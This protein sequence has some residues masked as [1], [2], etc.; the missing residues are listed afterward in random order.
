MFQ[1]VR[2]KQRLQKIY[3]QT[4]T[5]SLKVLL[6]FLLLLANAKQLKAYTSNTGG[7]TTFEVIS[8]TKIVFYMHKHC[9]F[10][11][12]SYGDT[13]DFQLFVMIGNTQTQVYP[14]YQYFHYPQY[15]CPATAATSPLTFGFGQGV[16]YRELV[17]KYTLDIS[18]K[19]FD[20]L[21]KTQPVLRIFAQ[22]KELSPTSWLIG[23]GTKWNIIYEPYHAWSTE[24]NTKSMVKGDKS[25][26]FNNLNQRQF[27]Q[28]EA[29]YSN[30]GIVYNPNDSVFTEL[31]PM[32]TDIW[33][34]SVLYTS[35]FSHKYP[36]TSY[37]PT[38]GNACTPKPNNKNKPIGFHCDPITGAIT[39]FHSS[40]P[41]TSYYE[42]AGPIVFKTSWY[43]KDAS[44]NWQFKGSITVLS[45]K[46]TCTDFNKFWDVPNFEVPSRVD[47][48]EGDSATINITMSDTGYLDT[49]YVKIDGSLNPKYYRYTV[50]YSVKY[51]P[52]I[53]LFI[54][55]PL[56]ADFSTYRTLN[57]ILSNSSCDGNQLSSRGIVVYN[58]KSISSKIITYPGPCNSFKA[59]IKSSNNGMFV[60][61]SWSVYKDS[62]GSKPIYTGKGDV[63]TLTAL[64]KGKY[65]LACTVS[66]PSAYC[67]QRIFRDSVDLIKLWPGLDFSLNH[68]TL[69]TAD[70]N[71]L[72]TPIN[73]SGFASKTTREWRFDTT[74]ITKDTLRKNFTSAVTLR[75]RITDTA[76]CDFSKSFTLF[77]DSVYQLD[78][79]TLE[80]L[81]GAQTVE[82]SGS[83]TV[84]GHAWSGDWSIT[85]GT[86]TTDLGTSK[87]LSLFLDAPKS[88]ITGKFTSVDGCAIALMREVKVDTTQIRI[89][90]IAVVCKATDTFN[91]NNIKVTPSGGTWWNAESNSATLQLK[92]AN[93]DSMMAIYTYSNSQC[94]FMDSAWVPLGDTAKQDFVT[95]KA[96]CGESAREDLTNLFN[97]STTGGTWYSKQANVSISK[98]LVIPRNT[99][100]NTYPVYYFSNTSP[101]GQLETH[102]LT[103]N[104][105][106]IAIDAKSN[107]T[108]AQI[109]ATILFEAKNLL[110]TA[111]TTYRWF[112][113]DP[114]SGSND[115][116]QVSSCSHTYTKASTYY[117]FVIAKAGNCVDTGYC[118]PIQVNPLSIQGIQS[119][120]FRVYPNPWSQSQPLAI[121]YWGTP[122]N[123]T[124]G[125]K[126]LM[127][128]YSAAGQLIFSKEMPSSGELT[129]SETLPIGVYYLKSNRTES[130]IKLI[131]VP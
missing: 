92:K 13:G 126:S 31:V 6:I 49:I 21:L 67:S 26:S 12:F 19:P 119:A 94:L 54:K 102:W 51:L 96:V 48:C 103:V 85:T 45:I 64:E 44:G 75:L 78:L 95:P 122:T 24:I 93:S 32:E 46:L 113:N 61:N 63:I 89:P 22:T 1:F 74:K 11:K 37:C 107:T 77:K 66:S 121:K 59:Q 7:Y 118:A 57:V 109:P 101:C 35:N 18:Q 114:T 131:V 29:N 25:V 4:M 71:Q 87:K 115:S 56:G 83:N 42:E 60:S 80:T 36:F 127:M 116:A 65:Y 98:G 106:V 14:T 104:P 123:A 124:I 40:R 129:I 108:T 9:P 117:P 5:K 27:I 47:I 84:T 58:Q 88:T 120:G 41:I 112:F 38:G 79:P 68:N 97:P 130:S 111:G 99:T 69:C 34:T 15:S 90:Q 17:Y 16:K 62:F 28:N 33:G 86:K 91:L 43:S 125:G 52:K 76:G 23:S 81:C 73:L 39:F 105:K 53:K 72:Y 8:N 100:A 55:L 128:C 20:S 82:L 2:M 10:V 110:G 50:D 70:T 30:P 3:A